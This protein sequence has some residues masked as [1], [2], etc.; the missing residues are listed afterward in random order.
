MPRALARTTIIA[1]TTED[2]RMRPVRARGE[3]IARERKAPLVLYDLDAAHPLEG[4]PLPTGW[5]AEGTA[6]RVPDRLGPADLERAGRHGIAAQVDE[7]RGRGVDAWGWL[8]QRSAGDELRR[9]ADRLH[10][11]TVL[12]PARDDPPGLLQRLTGRIADAVRREVGPDVEVEEVPV[13]AMRRE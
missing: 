4:S 5:S 13:Q 11:A 9:Y 12:V 3:A 10:A 6:E 1:Y 2:D 8:P 7:A